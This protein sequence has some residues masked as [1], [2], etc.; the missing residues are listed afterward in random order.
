MILLYCNSM[1]I[2]KEINE[3]SLGLGEVEQFGEK[4]ELR[5]SARAILQETEGKIAIQYLQNYGFR[6]LPG[7]GVDTGETLEEAVMREVREEVGC[8]C[9]VSEMIGVVIEYRNNY[10]LLQISYCFLAKIIGEKG[11]PTLEEG[12]VEEGQITLWMSPEEALQKMREDNP[13]K[14][15]GHFILQREITF[16]EKYLSKNINSPHPRCKHTGHWAS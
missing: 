9:E 16:L 11:I 3:H 6:K 15:E 10:N 2:L 5:K 8:A 7:G 1:E 12:E 4:Y 14:Y 13:R